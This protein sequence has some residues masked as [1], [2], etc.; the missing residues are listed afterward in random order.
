MPTADSPTPTP[1]PTP[2]ELVAAL[3]GP[4]KR[5]KKRELDAVLARAEEATPHLL[6]YLGEV[7]DGPERYIRLHPD[8][9]GPI[10]ALVLL[11]HL[12]EQA[13]PPLLLRLA[14]LPQAQIIALVDDLITM[15]LD[16]MLF[17]TS[18]DDTAGI[19]QIIRRHDAD[20]YIRGQAADALTWAVHAGWAE[21]DEVLAF[22]AAQLVPETAPQGS[23]SWTGVAS[24]ML[25]LHPQ[26]H[27]EAL[28]GAW[29]AGLID[30]ETFGPD[31]LERVIDRG[32]AD[33]ATALR[34][35]VER[36]LARG[37]HDW[38]AWWNGFQEAAASRAE[39]AQQRAAKAAVK[40]AH[41]RKRGA[42]KKPGKKKKRR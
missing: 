11:A 27:T 25:K 23:Y 5:Y 40:R 7:L 10:Y 14:R 20:E 17:V 4:Q 39:V 37:A 38:V 41:K 3:Q 33:A 26:E 12:R 8:C 22:L 9:Y 16:A 32:P 6:R 30:H 42:R 29:H 13:L 1:A 15:D 36:A 31:D 24:A 2:H 21:R 34:M 28:I 35:Q 19:R 18:G